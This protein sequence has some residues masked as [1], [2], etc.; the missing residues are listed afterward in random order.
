MDSSLAI[1]VSFAAIA[2]VLLAVGILGVVA[3]QK[4][5]PWTR[6]SGRVVRSGVE[7]RGEEFAA[8]VVYSYQHKN[9]EYTGNIVSFP[10]I[11]Y[12][13]R[14]PA[15]RICQRYPEG[16]TISVYV[17]PQNPKRS[18]LEPP[19]GVGVLALLLASVFFF[20]VAWAVK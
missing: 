3:G 6:V 12:N 18:V 7:Y 14:G 4:Q 17:D 20:V 8:A 10:Q 13:W 5:I 19:S 1:S 15:E 9:V 2:V 11:V 16:A